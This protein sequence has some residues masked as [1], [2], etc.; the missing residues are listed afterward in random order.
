MSGGR[1]EISYSAEHTF[2][3]IDDALLV[4]IQSVQA[5]SKGQ[6]NRDTYPVLLLFMST[7]MIFSLL[8]QWSKILKVD[9]N[10]ISTG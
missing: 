9:R 1:A 8:L 2:C 5:Y 4:A 7:F 3:M 6:A 10:S